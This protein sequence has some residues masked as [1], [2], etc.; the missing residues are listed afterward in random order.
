MHDKTRQA[1]NTF[2]DEIK[3]G[4]HTDPQD[5]AAQLERIRNEDPSITMGIGKGDG[6][7]F[8]HGDHDSI[9]RAQKI[10]LRWEQLEAQAKDT[11]TLLDDALRR[12]INERN[13]PGLEAVRDWHQNNP[14]TV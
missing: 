3:A 11:H 9:S 6:Q 2:I 7:L 10:V 5:I 8:V 14:R 4:H 1:L 12:G 13:R